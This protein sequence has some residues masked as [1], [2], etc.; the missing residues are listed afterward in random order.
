MPRIFDVICEGCPPYLGEAPALARRS[1]A[2]EPAARSLRSARRIGTALATSR[3]RGRVPITVP[4]RDSAVV[5]IVRFGRRSIGGRREERSRQGGRIRTRRIA[6]ASTNRDN[7]VAIGLVDSGDAAARQPPAAKST[8]D[9][10]RLVLDRPDAPGGLPASMTTHEHR[11][12]TVDAPS[13]RRRHRGRR[14][15]AAGL[16][17]ARRVSHPP[18]RPDGRSLASRAHASGATRATSPR[19]T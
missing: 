10:H 18:G 16:A 15:A 17:G 2:G 19:S 3:L 11:L 5:G 1:T 13:R 6:D 14:A 8:P 9:P 7:L 12:L 4:C